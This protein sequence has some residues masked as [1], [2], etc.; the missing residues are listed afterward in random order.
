V[1]IT[2]DGGQPGTTPAI[3]VRGP[4]SL[5]GG[6]PFVLV[7]GVPE[8]LSTVNS[9]DIQSI[10]VLKDAS[11]SAIYGVRAAYGVILVTTKSGAINS[12]PT[13]SYSGNIGWSKPTHLPTPA[14][15]LQWADA[16][17]DAAINAGQPPI[18]SDDQ[19]SRIKQY[20]KDP[21]SIP[22]YPTDAQYIAGAG[23]YNPGVGNANVNYFKV[24]YK[25]WQPSQTHNVNVSGGGNKVK[26]FIS[27]GYYDQGPLFRYGH[28]SYKRY[29]I[30][31]NITSDVTSW[32]QVGLRTRYI[33]EK[34]NMPHAYSGLGSYYHEIPRRWPNVPERDPLG[35]FWT[36][37]LVMMTSGGRDITDDEELLN[38]LNIV[39]TPLK[40][41]KINA[42]VNI[43][44]DFNSFDRHQETAYW[45]NYKDEPSPVAYTYPNW[46]ST[47]TTREAYNSSNIYSSYD[48]NAGK[49]HVTAM[50]GFQ[51]ELDNYEGVNGLRY[52]LVSDNIPSLSTATGD[53]QLSGPKGH[54]ATEGYFGRLNYNYDEK[55]LLEISGRYDGT[56]R[57]AP[58]H[59]WGL[60]P[61][62]SVGYNIARES[63][64][65]NITN[66][67]SLLKI[68]A[69]YGSLGNQDVS[70]NYYPYLSGLGVKTNLAWIMGTAR[71]LYIVA[72][73]LVSSDLTWET[74]TTLDFGL[75]A[76]A[77]NSR[78]AFTFDWYQRGTTNMFGPIES[79]PGVLGIK[80]PQT[81]NASLM[82][83]GFE[84]SVGWNDNIGKLSYKLQVVLSNNS[85]E[86]TK[87]H[88]QSGTLT[89]YYEGAHLG[90]I[91]GYVTK[92]IYQTD[93]A[94]KAGPDQSYLYSRWQAGDIAYKD[95]NGDGKID[96]GSNTLNDH[97]DLKVIG[98]NTPQYSYGIDL[99]LNWEN[100]DLSLFVQ[101]VAKRQVWLN[102]NYFW[103]FVGSTAQSSVFVQQL[104]YWR[105]DNTNAYYARPYMSSENSKNQQVQTRYLQNGAYMRL[106][107]FQLGYSIPQSMLGKIFLKQARIYF[108]GE[109]LL[110]FTKLS[111]SFDP[112][113]TGGG[114]GNGK[115]Y[116]LAET[117]SVGVNLT[118]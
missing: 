57:F 55:Y 72:P 32:L 20:L 94:A 95:L 102:S 115:L 61:S 78:L 66:K 70:S 68:R 8:D 65:K 44:H 36:Y 41:W 17:N 23:I 114:Y 83:K 29:N 90:D 59:R 27:G 9:N 47:N 16:F 28:E 43:K 86:V 98:N 40:G 2:N 96:K 33:E 15:S 54:W 108:T 89:D 42:D 97:G 99:S 51:A 45:Y 22:A 3:N 30:T 74:A 60:F 93:D 85:T 117:V 56:S 103:G 118:F 64:W 80:G 4:G 52:N 104:D 105:P 12:Q 48:F 18:F 31:S 101:G 113:A 38:S 34:T 25:D 6:S 11:A 82:T 100:F 111:K 7:D 69:S 91:W 1:S 71:P 87:Y 37:G 46:Y 10:T 19:I 63:F 92:G 81:N 107:N 67:V 24:Y 62:A 76:E 58:G 35:H 53:M 21:G 14:N 88:N 110:T 13:V 26:Y 39:M 50:L 109:N 49:N 84:L 116:P 5:S 79:Y 112:E 73:A 75:D 106:K 77:L